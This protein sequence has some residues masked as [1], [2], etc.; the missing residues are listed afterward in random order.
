MGTATKR[1]VPDL[2]KL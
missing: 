2:V 1:L